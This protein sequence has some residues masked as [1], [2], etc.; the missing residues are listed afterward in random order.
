MN[1]EANISRD[2]ARRLRHDVTS[3]RVVTQ[4]DTLRRIATQRE[5]YRLNLKLNES[6][7][8]LK[9]MLKFEVLFQM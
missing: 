4:R 5:K 8:Y 3:R 9:L 1:F 7:K 6:S 2:A